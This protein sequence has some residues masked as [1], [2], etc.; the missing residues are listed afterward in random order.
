MEE[1][2]PC[3]PFL[4]NPRAPEF[5]WAGGAKCYYL[6]FI[7]PHRP[8]AHSDRWGQS[9]PRCD[10]GVT[11]VCPSISD[12]TLRRRERHK[13]SVSDQIS[14][15][16]PSQ[17]SAKSTVG[18]DRNHFALGRPVG[19]AQVI[20]IPGAERFFEFE[21]SGMTSSPNSGNATVQIKKRYLLSSH[22]RMSRTSGAPKGFFIRTIL[23]LP[24]VSASAAAI[25]I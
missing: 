5:A 7:A 18:T 12:I 21:H 1:S 22:A 17:Q 9:P 16:T 6:C 13:G 15:I 19:D 24:L 10:V 11:S 8:Y 3:T 25:L 2:E 4:M 23:R 14:G 20:E